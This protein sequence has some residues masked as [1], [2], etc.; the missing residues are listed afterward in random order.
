MQKFPIYLNNHFNSSDEPLSKFLL[1][2]CNQMCQEFW[3]E[4][5]KMTHQESNEKQDFKCPHCNYMFSFED[6]NVKTE[7][8]ELLNIHIRLAH[9][10]KIKWSEL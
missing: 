1:K 8:T 2:I 10:E 5:N 7:A 4:L 3:T 6:N 9:P